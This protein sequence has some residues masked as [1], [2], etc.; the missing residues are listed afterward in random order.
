MSDKQW[1]QEDQGAQE[2]QHAPG[3]SWR[4]RGQGMSDKQW[5][6]EDRGAQAAQPAQGPQEA[7]G[8]S[9]AFRLLEPLQNSS[10]G[11]FRPL[12]PLQNSTSGSQ[13]SAARL[14]GSAA[15]AVASN[16]C[17]PLIFIL[18]LFSLTNRLTGLM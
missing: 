11:A 2:A 6:Q 4:L 7:P 8:G 18:M 13:L 5:A 9:G 1:A 16:F 10:S 12:E 15:V 3:G 17:Y 14:Q